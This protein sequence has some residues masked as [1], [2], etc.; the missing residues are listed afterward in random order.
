[1]L[2]RRFFA[3]NITKLL[4]L[5]LPLFV[6]SSSL[7]SSTAPT[8]K[9][10]PTVC[11]T[12]ITHHPS[13][14]T[15]REGVVDEL[16]SQGFLEDQSFK[17]IYDN[18]QGSSVT[19]AQ[20]AQKFASYNPN[21]MVAITTPSTQSLLRISK[22]YQIPVVF[23]GVTDPVKAKIVKS[24]DESNPLIVGV[25]DFQP[26]EDQLKQIKSLLPH[27]KTLGVLYNSSETNSQSQV[28]ALKQYV[29]GH[30]ISIIEATVSKISDTSAAARSLLP[31]VDAIF[32]P[33][34]NLIVS[35][36]DHLIVL[37]LQ[38]SKP[39]FASD[40]DSVQKGA[41]AAV[42]FDQYEIGRQAGKLAVKYLNG[43]KTSQLSVQ[44]AEKVVRYINQS[45]ARSMG[46]KIPE[47]YLNNSNIIQ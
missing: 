37:C 39:L 25:S 29:T 38:H 33:N 23:A 44:P 34:D 14:D 47:A 17:L 27:I 20:I 13:L 5:L 36:I 6:L 4:Y 30:N 21:V 1:M 16:K 9:S 41:L 19:A 31:K 3:D 22:E 2:Q 8:L 46:I 15:I 26:I 32:V 11:I 45:T 7:F 18:A 28:K 35:S 42:C 43:G 10:I 12:Q 24:I 40:N